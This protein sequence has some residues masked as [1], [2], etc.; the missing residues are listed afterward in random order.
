MS[1]LV[2]RGLLG[3]G[4]LQPIR[5][6]IAHRGTARRGGPAPVA[7]R[8]MRMVTSKSPSPPKAMLSKREQEMVRCLERRLSNKEI[9]VMFGVTERT[10]KFHV[11]NIL[12]KLNLRSRAD[13]ASQVF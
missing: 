6:R 9:A 4:G 12:R 10:V 3:G 7:V 5:G 13:I 11:S 8:W 1:T 2:E